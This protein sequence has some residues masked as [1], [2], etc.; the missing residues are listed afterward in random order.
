LQH[1]GQPRPVRPG[2]PDPIAVQLP[3]E[4]HDLVSQREDLGVLIAIAHR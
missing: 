4:N 3:F 1:G 2:E